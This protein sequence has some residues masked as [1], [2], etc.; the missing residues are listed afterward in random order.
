MGNIDRIARTL[1]GIFF[2]LGYIAGIIK[3]TIGTILA[4]IGGIFVVTSLI[5]FCPLYKVI[6]ISTCKV[7]QKE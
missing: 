5:G 3:G 6:G 1:I 2:I 4:I 7:E